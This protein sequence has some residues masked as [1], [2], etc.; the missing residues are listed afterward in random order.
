MSGHLKSHVKSIKAFIAVICHYFIPEI[1]EY[2]HKIL[3]K[4]DRQITMCV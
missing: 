4:L 2:K 3:A 1:Q